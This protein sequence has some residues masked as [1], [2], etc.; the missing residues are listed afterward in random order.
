MR[1]VKSAAAQ[2]RPIA[3]AA[4][5]LAERFTVVALDLPDRLDVAQRFHLV[6]LGAHE[7]IGLGAP[8]RVRRRML[9]D[10]VF[11]FFAII[12]AAF[13]VLLFQQ[14]FVFARG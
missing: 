8:P 14:G 13:A 11:G 1:L 3:M 12:N 9:A 10:Q 6:A 2:L 5:I 4:L 7:L